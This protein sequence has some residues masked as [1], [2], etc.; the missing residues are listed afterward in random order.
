MRLWQDQA[1]PDEALV[2]EGQ[3]ARNQSLIC[4]VWLERRVV[5]GNEGVNMARPER[6]AWTADRRLCS[7][8]PHYAND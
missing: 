4:P 5:G 2:L 1:P 6:L 3:P 7:I 8:T